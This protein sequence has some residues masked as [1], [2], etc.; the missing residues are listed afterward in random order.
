MTV[1]RLS[2]KRFAKQKVM[3]DAASAVA[4]YGSQI[5]NEL[6]DVGLEVHG[7]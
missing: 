5:G 7:M 6:A 1:S 2:T 4:D 3:V